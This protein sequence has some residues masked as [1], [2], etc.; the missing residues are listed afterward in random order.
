MKLPGLKPPAATEESLDEH[1]GYL[2]TEVGWIFLILLAGEGAI[3][4]AG[5]AV[6]SVGAIAQACH[7]REPIHNPSQ[8]SALAH[9]T[10]R[11]ALIM[12]NFLSIIS[13][14]NMT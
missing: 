12:C 7:V 5:L 3:L 11:H 13:R 2:L 8:T 9:C 10:S 4:F 6:V 14:A 1:V